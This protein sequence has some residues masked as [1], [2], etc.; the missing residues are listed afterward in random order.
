ML[1]VFPC[2]SCF[3]R[4]LLKSAAPAGAE[5]LIL[6]APATVMAIAPESSMS[7]PEVSPL[8]SEWIAL[9]H[10]H[11]MHERTAV[12]IKVAAVVLC[13]L[14]TWIAMPLFAS[15]PLLLV[16]WAIESV[17][18][19]VQARLGDRLLRLETLISEAAPASA[20]F[21]LHSEWLAGRPGLSGLLREY[22]RAAIRP[23]V[24]FPYA[25]LLILM[26]L[27]PLLA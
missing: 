4:T 19:T 24:A 27:L 22:A 1:A 18:R 5:I 7:P 17:A 9:Q 6:Q 16:L 25:P 15:I 2:A 11:E 20:A 12:A 8:Q 21:R 10:D 14:A 23:T 3:V 13:G 26:T